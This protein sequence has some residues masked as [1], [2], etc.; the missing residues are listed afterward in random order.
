[1]S[2]REENTIQEQSGVV[3][4]YNFNIHKHFYIQYMLYIYNSS[5]LFNTL[6]YLAVV[7]FRPQ[8]CTL[9]FSSGL[10]PLKV[11]SFLSPTNLM[12]NAL[13]FFVCFLTKI[14]S[15]RKYST[16]ATQNVGK[17]A[18]QEIHKLKARRAS[19]CMSHSAVQLTRFPSW[20][21]FSFSGFQFC[22]LIQQ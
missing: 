10:I 13:T 17:G 3:Q 6:F 11:F 14:A 19:L 9:Y 2:G 21:E 22:K 12:V 1:M 4:Q 7:A 16:V 18:K 5:F 20:D 15:Q 8:I